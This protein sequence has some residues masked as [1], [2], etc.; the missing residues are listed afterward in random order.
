MLDAAAYRALVRIAVHT[1]SDISLTGFDTR[2]SSVQSRNPPV[3][4]DLVYMYTETP[5]N[6]PPNLRGAARFFSELHSTRRK[7]K[8]QQ[9]SIPPPPPP[10]FLYGLEQECGGTRENPETGTTVTV[11]HGYSKTKRNLEAEFSAISTPEDKETNTDPEATRVF[12]KPP[13]LPLPFH[14]RADNI[15]HTLIEA[16]ELLSTMQIW[17]KLRKN[18]K[19]RCSSISASESAV[20]SSSCTTTETEPRT[21]AIQL[22]REDID[23]NEKRIYRRLEPD[24]SA[25][26]VRAWREEWLLEHTAK[27]SP[28]YIGKRETE[29]AGT[30][31]QEGTAQVVEKINLVIVAPTIHLLRAFVTT[32]SVIVK[33]NLTEAVNV[34]AYP[35]ENTDW[36]GRVVH[37]QGI[38]EGTRMALLGGE[39]A[40][41]ERYYAKGDLVHPTAVLEYLQ[42]R[43]K[44]KEMT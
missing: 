7:A 29:I 14:C 32:I 33:R 34:F 44:A 36:N 43:G 6:E 10:L 30:D 19:H 9:V 15:T 1:F 8:Q 12:W 41:I 13:I 42:K 39:I 28:G 2:S 38:A 21:E 35:G 18:G 22:Q 5:D 20:D 26:A 27:S 25:S 16:E 3:Q 23:I 17:E 4:I 24:A 40:R 37:S 31:T 11:F